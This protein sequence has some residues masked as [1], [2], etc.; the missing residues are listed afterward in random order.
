MKL[1]ITERQYKKLFEAMI[2]DFRIDYLSNA[3][4][5]NEKVR[6]C[7]KMLGAP[8]GSGS[9]RIVFQIDDETCLKLAKNK[10]GVAQNL[11]EIRIARDNFISYIPK[12][13]NG[14]D[15]ENG[16]WV[17]TQYVLPAKVN[18]FKQV[19]GIPFKD[20][21]EFAKYTDNRMNYKMSQN[22]MREAD[23]A[24]YALY[25]EYCNNDDVISLF[26]DISDLKANYDQL[27]GDLTRIQNW[28]MVR[29]NGNT[30]M[31]MLDTGFSEEIRNQFYKTNIKWQI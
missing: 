3:R 30:F 21:A 8:I 28:G 4:S 27:V 14:S 7:K 10:K 6:Y 29:E 13:Y 23:K 1:L 26:N 12:I 9:S 31:V 19:L 20:V 2:P 16:L 24:I 25:D 11:E 22:S 5:F 17:I 18:D 15:E